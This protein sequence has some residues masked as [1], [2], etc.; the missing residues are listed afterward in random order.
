MSLTGRIR[1]NTLE[2]VWENGSESFQQSSIE[3]RGD[4]LRRLGET[5][6]LLAFDSATAEAFEKFTTGVDTL[7]SFVER[8]DTVIDSMD[9]AQSH[10]SNVMELLET[11][12][13]Q[14]TILEQRD[15]PWQVQLDLR[16]EIGNLEREAQL[17]AMNVSNLR[18]QLNNQM[19]S[20]QRNIDEAI[21]HCNLPRPV[22]TEIEYCAMTEVASHVVQELIDTLQPS[23]TA[24][25]KLLPES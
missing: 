22:P 16:L 23:F 4:E 5:A 14:L 17:I 11:R 24:L 7:M 10:Y 3:G 2:L 6:A 25:D 8:T 21:A 20:V 12:R 15:S 1:G 13:R 18:R 19:R 9:E